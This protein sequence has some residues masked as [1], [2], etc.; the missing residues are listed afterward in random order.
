[1]DQRF[2]ILNILGLTAALN[3]INPAIM[4][5]ERLHGQ[6]W[7]HDGAVKSF[8]LDIQNDCIEIELFVKRIKRISPY[9]PLQQED[10]TPCTLYLKFEKLIEVSLLNKFPTQGYYL[11]FSTFNKG[12]EGIEVCFNVHDNSSSVYE[13]PNWVIM[14]KR[15]VWKEV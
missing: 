6:Y 14:A 2:Q 4:N 13:K 9:G 11:N 15:V 8:R 1:L 7:F 12:S 3:A 10:L 5:I